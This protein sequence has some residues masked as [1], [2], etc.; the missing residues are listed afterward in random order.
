MNSEETRSSLEPEIRAEGADPTQ[1]CEQG[2]GSFFLGNDGRL[3]SGWRVAAF[4]VAFIFLIQLL[5][6]IVL[7]AA[8]CVVVTMTGGQA[9][10]KEFLNGS[11]QGA[12]LQQ[13]MALVLTPAALLLAWPFRRWLDR[14]SYRSMGFWWDRSTGIDLFLG[15]VMGSALVMLLTG[16]FLLSGLY[17]WK[18]TVAFGSELALRMLLA[19]A[20]LAAAAMLEELVFRAYVQSNLTESIGPVWALAISSLGFAVMHG[21]NPNVTLFGLINLFAAGVLLGLVYHRFRSI[22]AVWTMHFAWNFTMGPLLGVPVSGVTM[23]SICRVELADPNT[24]AR[25][26]WWVLTGGPFGL[27]G[28]LGATV[29]MGLFIL[30]LAVWK[31]RPAR[32]AEP[33]GR[34]A[35]EAA[36]AGG[37]APP[38]A[39]PVSGP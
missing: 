10:L 22:W 30:G 12:A 16:A 17:L 21:A 34:R 9:G 32:P 27:E 37:E 14:R 8:I 7:I 3:R 33:I 13:G 24:L 18:G 19:V 4:L 39:P 26:D 23:A 31:G 25:P 15:L 29:V 1:R 28:G 11:L 35:E 6:P 5:L 38:E 2:S 36:E 20:G